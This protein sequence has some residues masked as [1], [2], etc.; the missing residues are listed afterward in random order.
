MHALLGRQ[1]RFPSPLCPLAC[2]LCAVRRMHNSTQRPR[3]NLCW[4]PWSPCLFPSSQ[5]RLSC[6][7]VLSQSCFSLATYWQNFCPRSNGGNRIF[8]MEI[9]GTC[10]ACG[11][12]LIWFGLGSCFGLCDRQSYLCHLPHERHCRYRTKEGCSGVNR[13]Y[14]AQGWE[15]ECREASAWLWGGYVLGPAVPL[16]TR[17]ASRGNGSFPSGSSMLIGFSKSQEPGWDAHF[18]AEA[19]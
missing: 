7:S 14:R 1:S 16:K 8:R 10:Q 12:V 18:V 9:P 11:S 13:A 5:Q 15:W 2:C 17:A 19:L 6:A 3:E 4:S